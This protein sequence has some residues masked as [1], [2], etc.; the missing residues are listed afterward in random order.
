MSAPRRVFAV[1]VN[2][3]GGARMNLDCLAS[4]V[5]E[6][7][8]PE[9]IVFVDNASEDGSLEEVRLA[10]PRLRVVR[11]EENLGF[12]PASNQGMQEALSAGADGVL[13]VNNDLVLEPGCL[14]GLVLFLA[15]Q[16]GVGLCGPRILDAADPTRLWAAGGRVGWGPNLTFLRGHGQAD[17]EVWRDSVEVDFVPGCALLVTG[18]ALVD[19]GGFDPAYFAYMEDVDL[20]LRARDAGHRAALVGEVAARHSGSWSTG[21]GYNPRRK[22]MMAVN[23]VWFLRRHGTLRS[24]TGFVLFDVLLLPLAI[25]FQA[26]RGNGRAALAKARGIVDGLRG[27]RVTAAAARRG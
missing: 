23:S 11:N 24:W 13:F 7:L 27:R 9:R 2:W 6:G 4:L 26:L 5:A 16:P 22:Y 10:H 17:G 20:G 8:P 25:A 14:A 21:G 19:T 1:V 3:N 18:Q 12:A 15:E